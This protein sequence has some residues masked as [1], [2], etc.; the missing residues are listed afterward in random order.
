MFFKMNPNRLLLLFFILVDSFH[1]LDEA[2]FCIKLGVRLGIKTWKMKTQELV[3]S[4]ICISIYVFF[5]HISKKVNVRGG[6][7]PK[8]DQVLA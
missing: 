8:L 5:Y 2:E 4:T 7:N 3:I 6:I 1:L